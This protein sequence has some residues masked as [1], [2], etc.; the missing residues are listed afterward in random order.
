[1]NN[2][3]TDDHKNAGTGL[4]CY[5][6]KMYVHVMQKKRAKTTILLCFACLILEFN[7]TKSYLRSC[8]KCLKTMILLT[9]FKHNDT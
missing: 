1:M 9:S 3:T 5:L 7:L 2:Y 6:K 8:C 4:V